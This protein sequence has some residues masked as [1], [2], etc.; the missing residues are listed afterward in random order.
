LGTTSQKLRGTGE[1][2]SKSKK[3]QTF[4]NKAKK[5]LGFSQHHHE[6][7]Y[8]RIKK[9]GGDPAEC[10]GLTAKKREKTRGSGRKNR[11]KKTRDGKGLGE[12]VG[13]RK[14]RRK[15]IEVQV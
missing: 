9:S 8:F 1:V 7:K 10:H 3:E 6:R 11:Q 5:T 14:G 12:G 13:G 4:L 15:G 2:P